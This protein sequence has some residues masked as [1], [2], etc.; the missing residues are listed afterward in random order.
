MQYNNPHDTPSD[1]GV[2]MTNFYWY[3][4]ALVD[5][6]KEMYFGQLAD[7]KT[8]PKHYGKTMKLYHYIPLLDDRNVNDQGIDASGATITNGNLYGSSK[9][10]GVIPGKLPVLTENGGR[11]NRVGF[12]RVSLEGSITKFGF[13]YDWTQEAM[14]FDN[15]A[16]LMQH[17]TTESVRGANEITEDQLQIDLLNGAGVVRYPGV[18]MAD[19]DLTGEGIVSE[20]TYDDLIKL[21]IT[22]NDNRCP[23]QTTVIK[24]SLMTDTRTIP[25]AR[26]LYVGSELELTL[27]KMQDPFGNAAFIPVQ[28]YADGGNTL[29]GEIGTIAHFRIIVVPEMMKYAG[30]GQTAIANPG[31]HETNGKYDGFPM[32]C[33]GS[34]SFATIG[35]QT[36]GKSV[37]FVTTT[38]KPGPETASPADP[39]GETGF[40]SIKWYYGSIIMRPEWIGMIK[41][42]AAM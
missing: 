9:D 32:L 3:K 14:D 25:G 7:G 8:M 28:H 35:F 37:K 12:T 17:L 27:R 16:E 30:V 11:V 38:K 20:V 15:D 34:G 23:M 19:E 22:L 41:T 33:V 5:A 1:I 13:F 10:I 26:A 21:G 24:G 36:D 29:K 42:V 4:K 31:Y 40:T 6:A 39:Y 18:A 2:Q